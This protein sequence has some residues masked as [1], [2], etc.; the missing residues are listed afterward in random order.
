[1]ADPIVITGDLAEFSFSLGNATL[2]PPINVSVPIAGSGKAKVGGKPVCV[3][4]DEKKV[5]VAVA[6]IAGNFAGGAGTLTIEAL[7]PGQTSTRANSGG[8]PVL[9]ARGKFKATLT[10]TVKAIDAST[11]S[12]DPNASY[13][14]EGEFRTT[15][16]RSKLGG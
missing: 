4:G 11:G 14:G 6:Y 2:V 13:A 8:K 3:A 1:M 10:V 12:P 7:D 15:N 9:L 5:V 16:A